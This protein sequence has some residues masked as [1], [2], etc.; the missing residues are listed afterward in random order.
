MVAVGG[1][2]GTYREVCAFHSASYKGSATYSN[3]MQHPIKSLDNVL[4]MAGGTRSILKLVKQLSVFNTEHN[5]FL[6]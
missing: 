6:H 5:M 1:C 3:H 2:Y 4:N